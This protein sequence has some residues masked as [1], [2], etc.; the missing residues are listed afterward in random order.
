MCAR[1][2]FFLNFS[3]S[4]CV[5]AVWTLD[6]S[7]WLKKRISFVLVAFFLFT[8]ALLGHSHKL[9][10][11]TTLMVTRFTQE[12]TILSTYSIVQLE[13]K[14]KLFIILYSYMHVNDIH[15]NRPKKS[16]RLKRSILRTME[17]L[18]ERDMFN[19]DC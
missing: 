8:T 9:M 15:S 1:I 4:L 14:G 2:D 17:R 13:W 6:N 7:Y 12:Q 5:M 18:R 11:K 3:P 10:K 19:L 16:N